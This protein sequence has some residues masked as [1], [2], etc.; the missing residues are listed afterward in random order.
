MKSQIASITLALL[1][2][3]HAASTQ[4][5]WYGCDGAVQVTHSD[6][7][8]CTNVSGMKSDNLCKVFVPPP[9]TDR[10][11]FYSTMC[12]NPF[13]STWYCNAGQTCDATN[14]EVDSYRCYQ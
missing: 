5:N 10:C 12:G 8:S 3:A 11:E 4:V 7:D 2:G 9:G 6:G 13:G 1:A 14:W